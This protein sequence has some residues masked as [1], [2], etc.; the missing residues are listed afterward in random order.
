MEGA[1]NTCFRIAQFYVEEANFR[2]LVRITNSYDNGLIEATYFCYVA[3]AQVN[4][5]CITSQSPV[6]KASRALCEISAN[7]KVLNV[8]SFT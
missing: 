4:Q 1:A 5:S 2:Q 8:A 3:D 6:A 7:E